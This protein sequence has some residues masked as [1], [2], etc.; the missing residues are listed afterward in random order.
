[1]KTIVLSSHPILELQGRFLHRLNALKQTVHSLLPVTNPVGFPRQRDDLGSFLNRLGLLGE[2]AEIGSAYG[3]F[4]RQILKQWNGRMLHMIDPWVAHS[5]YSENYD[6]MDWYQQCLNL[7]RE[8]DRVVLHKA[9]SN[10][11]L[12]RFD[13]ESLDWVYLDGNHSYEGITCDM[14]WHFKVKRGGIVAGHDYY[15]N[16]HPPF[17]CEVRRALDEFTKGIGVKPFTNTKC[18]SWYYVRP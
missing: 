2:G 8:D 15:N 1:M 11:A 7:E 12:S 13:D 18:T 16:T 14:Q 10:D 5:D 6:F 4:A 9:F 17:N 3:A